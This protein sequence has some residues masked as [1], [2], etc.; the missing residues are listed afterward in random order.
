[1]TR[2]EALGGN[3]FPRLWLDQMELISIDYLGFDGK[4]HRG[5]LVVHRSVAEE[6]KSIFAEILAA[7][8]P[9][10]KAVP[11]VAYGWHDQ[12]SIDDD[13][14]SG[15]NYRK[16]IGPGLTGNALSK[17]SFGRAIDV[18]PYENP[19][20]PS[21]GKGPRPYRPAAVGT[22]AEQS[23]VV[24]IFA[25]HGWLWGGDWKGAKDYQHF[26]KP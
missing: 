8:F 3:A 21:E 6:V 5:Q 2:E 12:S 4:R 11:I 24:V 7:G 15:F 17:H 25:R 1:M 23:A 19:F 10:R 18:N 13:N 14:T 20:M 26:Y 9:I 22:I 16:V